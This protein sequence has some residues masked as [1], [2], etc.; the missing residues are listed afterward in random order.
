MILV[1]FSRM[2]LGCH[3]PLDV[4]VSFVIALL[5]AVTIRPL[6]L[7]N[8]KN[9]RFLWIVVA[10]SMAIALLYWA[11]VTFYP[12]PADVD[13]TNLSSGVK[14]SYR[15][16]GCIAGL[17]AAKAL[18]DRYIHFEVEA[19]WQAQILKTGLGMLLVLAI[20]TGLKAPLQA[21]FPIYM[22]TTIRYSLVVFFAGAV[23]PLTFPWFT[24]LVLPCVNSG[25]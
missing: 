22:A 19:P 5:L 4:G 10:I 18:D 25:E 16:T 9:P 13:L 6:V 12:F 24:G 17:A 3:T 11:F 20:M 23:W 7:K 15:L 1:P 8:E 21:V 2:Y 14:N